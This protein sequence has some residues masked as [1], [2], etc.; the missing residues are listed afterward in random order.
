MAD[1]RPTSRS[2]EALPKI[3]EVKAVIK[4]LEDGSKLFGKCAAGLREKRA[5]DL[6]RRFLDARGCVSIEVTP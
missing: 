2:G 4:D 6:L 5:A 3:E 1:M